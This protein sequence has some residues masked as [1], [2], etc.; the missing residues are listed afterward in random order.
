VR[1]PFPEHSGSLYEIL[2]RRLWS[3][4]LRAVVGSFLDY[5]VGASLPESGSLMIVRGGEG[6]GGMRAAQTG[7]V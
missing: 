6:S 4:K 5:V 3:P 7:E 1:A 2:L